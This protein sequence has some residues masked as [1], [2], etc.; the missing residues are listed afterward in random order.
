[1]GKYEEYMGFDNLVAAEIITDDADTYET[2]EVFSV[3]PA[4]EIKKSTERS[5]ATKY[6]DNKAFLNII[7]EGSDTVELVVPILPLDI[8]AKLT[9]KTQDPDTKV[10][11]DSGVPVIKYFALGYRLMKSDGTYRCIWKNKGTFTM[12]DEEAKSKDDSTDSSNMTLT[13]TA[14]TTAHVFKKEN[15]PSKTMVVDE[16][17]DAIL[18]AKW[19]DQVVTPDNMAG[20]NKTSA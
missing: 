9:G 17:D 11:L 6:Y 12:G 4:G 20:L 15:K 5:T 8:E 19:F 16:F 13:Y 14:I 18:S 7:S 1:M 10:L 3:A 2:G